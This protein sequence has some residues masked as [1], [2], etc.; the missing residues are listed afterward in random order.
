MWYKNFNLLHKRVFLKHMALELS[1]TAHNN[2]F[3]KYVVLEFS[4]TAH[5][6]FGNMSY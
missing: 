3:S 1:F 5:T 4:L 2:I 6:H